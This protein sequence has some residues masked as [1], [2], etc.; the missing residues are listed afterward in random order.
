MYLMRK[1]P[2]KD[3]NYND[4]FYKVI[5]QD[6]QDKDEVFDLEMSYDQVKQIFTNGL[7]R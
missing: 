1:Y 7:P 4:Y 2:N 6:I 5:V 3:N